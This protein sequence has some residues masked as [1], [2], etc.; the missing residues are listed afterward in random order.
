MKKSLCCLW[1]SLLVIVVCGC[2]PSTMTGAWRDQTYRN[3]IRK[4]LIIGISKNETYRRIFEDELSQQIQSRGTIA[5]PS[6]TSFTAEELNDRNMVSA[7][8]KL[9]EFDAMLISK[10]T[11]KRSEESVIPGRSYFTGDTYLPSHAYNHWHDYYSK[12]YEVMYEPP[13]IISY[14]VVTVESNLYDMA[15]DKL[16]WGMTSE[17]VVKTP[18]EEMIKEFTSFLLENLETENLL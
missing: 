11:G 8:I 15:T 10:M 5:V 13:Q 14:K 1:A 9:L 16:I 6:Y 18:T 7:K 17:T 2:S 12:N 4:V 3:H